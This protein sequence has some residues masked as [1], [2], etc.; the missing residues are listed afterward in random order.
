[1]DI[2]WIQNKQRR[3]PVTVPDIISL[4]QTGELTED[5]LA[6]HAGCNGWLPLKELPALE[7]FFNKP[8]PQE[9]PPDEMTAPCTD[10]TSAPC[11]SRNLSETE[12]LPPLPPGQHI[13]VQVAPIMPRLVA[14]LV[15][16][17]MYSVIGMAIVYRMK[18]AYGDISLPGML[19]FW[20]PMILAEAWLLSRFGSTPGK[21]L[22][23]IRVIPMSNVLTELPFRRA[24]LRSILNFLLGLGMML[25]MPA[26][27]MG[28]FNFFSLRLRGISG[29]DMRAGT[30]PVRMTPARPGIFRYIFALTFIYSCLTLNGYFTQPWLPEI[31]EQLDSTNPETARYFRDTLHIGSQNPAAEVP[32]IQQPH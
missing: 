4:L 9:T 19:L 29:W 26:L 1:M 7:D 27:V 6:W 30:L 28:I 15:D 32:V 17:A 23:L 22:M 5:T 13:T 11:E 18:I 8:A 12:Q 3:G 16:I 25:P 21:K 24:L 10:G 14:R 2:Y 20:L 31:I